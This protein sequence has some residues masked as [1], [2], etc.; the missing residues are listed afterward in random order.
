MTERE[1]SRCSCIR[2]KS[3]VC[4][5]QRIFKP[6]KWTVVALTC[7]LLL[8]FGWYCLG[9]NCSKLFK[10]FNRDRLHQIKQSFGREITAQHQWR[11]PWQRRKR[12]RRRQLICQRFMG[13]GSVGGRVGCTAFRTG[14]FR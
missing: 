4:L 13:S 10:I 14:R 6:T 7:R 9:H 3:I 5:F 1:C 8:V 12:R 11:Q 2:S